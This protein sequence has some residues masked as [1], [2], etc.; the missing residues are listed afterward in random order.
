MMIS[1]LVSP[2]RQFNSVLDLL[3]LGLVREHDCRDLARWHFVVLHIEIPR[4]EQGILHL[5]G[6]MDFDVKR[7]NS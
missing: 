7:K 1:E 6:P 2:R 4:M 5:P 3:R